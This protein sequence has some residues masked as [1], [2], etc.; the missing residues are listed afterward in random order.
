MRLGLGLGLS[1]RRVISATSLYTFDDA[2]IEIAQ[3]DEIISATSARVAHGGNGTRLLF[4]GVPSGDYIISG[5]FSD[6]DGAV[7][8]ISA[9]RMRIADNFSQLGA[10]VESAGA[11]SRTVT[12]ASGNLRLFPPSSVD[13]FRIDDFFIE[14]A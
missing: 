4:T 13:G 9:R 12:I 7:A 11:F 2:T 8:G 5:T 3:G 14:A 1:G 6:Y 10:L